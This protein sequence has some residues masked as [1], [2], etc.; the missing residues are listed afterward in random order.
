MINY[1]FIIPHFNTPS[2]LDRL[3]QS[4]PQRKDVEVIVVD[5]NSASDK[6]PIV[7]RK[8][9]KV[10]YLQAE[11]SKGAGHARNIGLEHAVGK[12]LLFADADD[13]YI[14]DFIEKLDG[15]KDSEYDIVFFDYDTNLGTNREEFQKSLVLMLQ[16][17]K[18]EKANFKHSLNAPWNKMYKRQFV[19]DNSIQ[20]EEIPIQNDAY[21]VH[22]ASSLTNNFHYINE[23]LYFYEINENGIT[24]KKRCRSDLELSISTRI[25]IDKLKADSGAWDCI[26]FSIMKHRNYK[27]QGLIFVFRQQLRRIRYGLLWYM[28]RKSL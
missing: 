8:D 17:G 15:L 23:K 14:N 25:K 6:K 16:G 19:I 28:I 24:R 27:D 21:F 18:R 10:V 2:L 4:I 12:W 9:V 13:Y 22:K 26:G 11:E 20:F 1:S 3:L 5:D 7:N